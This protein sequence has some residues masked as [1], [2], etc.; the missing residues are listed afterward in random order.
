MPR[1]GRAR[2]QS[3]WCLPDCGQRR[4]GSGRVGKVVDEA[5]PVGQLR[6]GAGG[7]ASRCRGAGPSRE[8]GL[9]GLLRDLGG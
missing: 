3:E 2:R 4:G 9:R 5:G 6:L 1:W 7:A 8:E